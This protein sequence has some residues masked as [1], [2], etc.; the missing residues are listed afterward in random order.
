ML[1]AM[2]IG[3]EGVMVTL[4]ANS[5]REALQRLETLVLM[6]GIDMP[7][8]AVRGNVALAVDLLV[9]VAR[10]SDGTRRIVQVSEVTGMELDNI[11]LS[12]IFVTETRKVRQGPA[13][14]LRPTGAIPRFF[15]KLQQ[16]GF[17]PPFHLFKA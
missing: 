10:L 1:Q 17:E 5:C 9:F 13:F 2:N 11:L 3:Q 14:S 4:H 7:L 12:D 8:R 16:E 15:E 6:A